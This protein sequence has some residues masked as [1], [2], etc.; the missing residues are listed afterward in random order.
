MVYITHYVVHRK[1]ESLVHIGANGWYIHGRDL[2][3]L[4]LVMVASSTG[5]W[6][7]TRVQEREEKMNLRA[8]GQPSL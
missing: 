2:T 1:R 4:G 8:D 3:A 7:S 6:I 5:L